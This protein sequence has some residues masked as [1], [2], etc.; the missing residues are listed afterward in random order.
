[1]ADDADHSLVDTADV[2]QRSEQPAAIQ[3]HMET[4]LLPNVALLLEGALF[5]VCFLLFFGHC[6]FQ[7]V[8]EQ[9]N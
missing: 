6:C 3:T 9:M 8:C 4:I 7:S 5:G 1:M 2:M